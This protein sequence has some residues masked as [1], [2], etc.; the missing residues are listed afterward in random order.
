MAWTSSTATTGVGV[1]GVLST[2]AN[3][4]L[5]TDNSWW[6][7]NYL[8]IY[9][10]ND[11]VIGGGGYGF[12]SIGAM[13]YPERGMNGNYAYI[14]GRAGD[15]VLVAAA[16]QGD[17]YATLVGGTGTDSY[18]FGCNSDSTINVVLDT[19]G[20][21]EPEYFAIFYEGYHD[22]AF[23]A[24]LTDSGGIIRDDAGRLNVT[25]KG[26]DINYDL[27]YGEIWIYPHGVRADSILNV[28]A[29]VWYNG[30]WKRLGEVVR[31]G[32]Y[33]SGLTINGNALSVNDW[34]SGGVVTNGVYGLDGLI[35]IDNTQSTTARY[36]GGNAQANQILAGNGGDTIW[37]AANNDVLLGGAGVDTF[38]YGLSE[39]ADVVANSDWLDTVSL[40]NMT[41]G[42][43]SGVYAEAGLVVVGLDA[44]NA[45][46][47]QYS[48]V[49]S[50]LI[51]LADGSQYRYNGANNSWQN[52]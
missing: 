2:T 50:P 7:N 46:A 13:L 34:H 1:N 48:G 24:Y 45:V 38:L 44:N 21:N 47:I 42:N 19:S 18:G 12:D 33:I 32:G 3:N 6:D 4:A 52:A 25:L 15:D 11:T 40:Y 35:V 8:E 10:A 28:A 39:G 23:T 17:M 9:G 16:I 30:E 43:I 36:L 14:D 5:I 31:Y 29:E 26:E 51:K 22:A 37:G 20:S 49:Y 27:N 41:L